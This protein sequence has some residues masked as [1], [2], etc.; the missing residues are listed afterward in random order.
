MKIKQLINRFFAS[1]S[2]VI[3]SAQ[4]IKGSFATYAIL[5]ATP[6]SGRDAGMYIVQNDENHV[7]TGH[8]SLYSNDLVSY[9]WISVWP[10]EADDIKTIITN[11]N[12]ILSGSDDEVQKALDTLDD[13]KHSSE[14]YT[15]IIYFGKGGNDTYSGLSPLS[16]KLTLASAKTAAVALTP[17]ANKIIT[18]VCQDSGEYSESYSSAEYINLDLRNAKLTGNITI[19]HDISIYLNDLNGNLTINSLKTLRTYILN[20]S[21]GSITNNGIIRGRIGSKLWGVSEIQF[22]T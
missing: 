8:G 4:G 17:A 14:D 2:D 6:P 3:A 12:K 19:A 5:T 9:T 22:V 13:H 11:F 20:Q 10:Y 21:S 18:I 15:Q 16:R 1:K 7:P